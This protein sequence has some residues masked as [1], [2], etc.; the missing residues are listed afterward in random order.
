MA[1]DE[2]EDEDAAQVATV[3]TSPPPFTCISYTPTDALRIYNCMCTCIHAERER[4]GGG[5]RVCAAVF[6]KLPEILSRAAN[7]YSICRK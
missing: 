2:D 5:R 7:I 3:R 6:L 4:D 1:E